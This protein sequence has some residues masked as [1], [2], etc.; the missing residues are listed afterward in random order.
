MSRNARQ[1][2]YNVAPHFV[3][4]W[5]PRSFGEEAISEDE[6]FACFEAARWAPSGFNLQPWPFIY[7]RRET[8]QWAPFADLLSPNNRAWAIDAAA[9]VLFVSKT[10]VVRN[11]EARPA[12]SHAFDAGAA[13]SNFAHQAQLTG[14]HTHAIGGFDKDRARAE[15]GIPDDFAINVIA[16]IGRLGPKGKLP[17]NLQEQEFPRGRLPLESLVMEGRFRSE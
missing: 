7:A 17:E 6:L 16:A 13:W 10:T 12:T 4:R 5:S 9:L 2:Q 3:E 11:G 15:L 1:S 14:W 8:P